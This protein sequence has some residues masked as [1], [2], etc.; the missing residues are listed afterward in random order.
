MK[1]VKIDATSHAEYM[2]VLP[3]SA[4][5]LEWNGAQAEKCYWKWTIEIGVLTQE[6]MGV[7]CFCFRTE[8]RTQQKDILKIKHIWKELPALCFLYFIQKYCNAELSTCILHIA[9]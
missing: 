6:E 4:V 8:M 2:K 5:A 7:F 3:I 1:K 9:Q